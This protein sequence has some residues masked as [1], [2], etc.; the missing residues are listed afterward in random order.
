[1]VYTYIVYTTGWS[2]F[3]VVLALWG[4]INRDPWD[5]VLIRILSCYIIFYIIIYTTEQSHV[6]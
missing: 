5:T 4:K 1:M 3:P 6:L 2:G